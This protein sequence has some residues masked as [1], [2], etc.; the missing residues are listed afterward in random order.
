M[1]RF[2][3]V[4]TPLGNREDLSPRAARE[5]LAADVLLCEDTRSPLRL[6]GPGT[7][8]PPRVSCFE[9]N[10]AQR[11]DRLLGELAAGRTVAYVSEAG[12]PCWSDPGQ[13]LVE[14]AAAA[15]HVVE[16]VPGPTAVGAAVAL[17]GFPGDG[18]LF[19]GFLPRSGV[20]RRERLDQLARSPQAVVVYEAGNRTADLLRELAAQLEDAAE[21]RVAVCRELT[22][23]HEEVTR[24]VLAEVALALPESLRGEVTVVVEG[25]RG[26][27]VA[28]DAP[29]SAARQVFELLLDPRLRPRARARELAP[30][31]GLDAHEVYRRLAAHRAGRDG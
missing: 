22:K 16:V 27:G 8:L 1:A 20:E 28:A 12:M 30:L 9:G 21:R 29:A 6:F 18:V 15:G 4:G 14:A 7:A 2:I 25:R 19:L 5:I 23:V 17:A 26:G 24:G 13:R 31:L 11:V 3:L 10:E